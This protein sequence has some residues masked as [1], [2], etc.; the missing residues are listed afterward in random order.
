MQD[1]FAVFVLFDINRGELLFKH[2]KCIDA[3]QLKTVPNLNAFALHS[4][5]KKNRF[6]PFNKTEIHLIKNDFLKND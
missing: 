2:I 4:A 1:L 5:Q 6:E 3:V